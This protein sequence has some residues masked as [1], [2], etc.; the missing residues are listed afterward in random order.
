MNISRENENGVE[1]RRMQL[2]N[3]NLNDI[4]FYFNS[5]DVVCG[6]ASEVSRYFPLITAQRQELA[7]LP[8]FNVMK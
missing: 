7:L 8:C 2:I 3:K 6:S 5:F 1:K 4:Y